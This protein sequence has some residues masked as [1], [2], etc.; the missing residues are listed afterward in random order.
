MDA[1]TIY[2][3]VAVTLMMIAYALESR[4]ATFVLIFA[5]ACLASSVYGFLQGAGRSEWLRLSGRAWPSHGGAAEQR[6]LGQVLQS[7]CIDNALSIMHTGATSP[8]T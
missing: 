6:L 4:A 7:S 1:L 3:A 2:G 8:R 5:S